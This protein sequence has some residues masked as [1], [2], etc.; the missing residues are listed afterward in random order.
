M[1]IAAADGAAD[2][3]I[4]FAYVAV[5]VMW[6]RLVLRLFLQYVRNDV[7]DYSLLGK[8]QGYDKQRFQ[9][10]GT[11]HAWHSNRHPLPFQAT[12]RT[13]G[14]SRPFDILTW[15]EGWVSLHTRTACSALGAHY[16]AAWSS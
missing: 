10:C 2:L 6:K 14:I 15:R 16:S 11:E 13:A 12:R 3:R 4:D 5:P 7:R 9:E 1:D 8:Q